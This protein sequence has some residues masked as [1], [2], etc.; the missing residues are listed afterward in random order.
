LERTEPRDYEDLFRLE[1]PAVL[2]TVELIVRDHGRAEEI[3]QDAFVKLL[4]EWRRISRYDRPDAWVRRVAIRLAVR[5]LRRDDLW[6]RVRETL[7]PRSE[8]SHEASDS[9]YDLAAAIRRLSA[10]QRAAVILHYYDDRSTADIAA[11]LGCSEST[12]RVHLHHARK[13]LARLLQ[14]D[15]RVD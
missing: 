13:R 3:T 11:T 7:R 1:F 8:E 10:A 14:E 5:T 4:I 2:R 6:R 9:P 15:D 12:A